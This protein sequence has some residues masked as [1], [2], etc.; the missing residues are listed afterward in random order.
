ALGFERV[1]VAARVVG[2]ELVGDRAAVHTD[3]VRLA[4]EQLE[5]RA[6]AVALR[7]FEL[8]DP[9]EQRARDHAAVVEDHRLDHGRHVTGL[10]SQTASGGSSAI[11]SAPRAVASAMRLTSST[12]TSTTT[13]TRRFAPA[14]SPSSCAAVGSTDSTRA[15][16]ATTAVGSTA[17]PTSR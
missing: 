14:V 12:V 1:G 4:E 9:A 2:R 8:A 15:A 6:L 17:P 11:M 7:R 13:P 3:V 16:R 10:A 5:Q